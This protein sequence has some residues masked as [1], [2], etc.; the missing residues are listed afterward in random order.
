[1]MRK[2][3][4][5]THGAE[6]ESVRISLSQEQ[7]DQITRQIVGQGNPSEPLDGVEHPAEAIAALADSSLLED[8]RISRSVLIG[9]LTLACFAPVGAERRLVDVAQILNL[10]PSS[11]H[12]YVRTLVAVGLLEQAPVTREYRLPLGQDS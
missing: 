8:R 10:P 7:L 9:L 3:S 11:I 5:V 6:E 12:R 2:A 4:S 1:M